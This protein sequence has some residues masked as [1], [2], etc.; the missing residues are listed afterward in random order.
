[1][2]DNIIPQHASAVVFCGR[3]GSGKSNLLVNLAERPEFYGKTKKD[4]PKT[5]YFDLILCL[6]SRLLVIMTTYRNILTYH[7]IECMI[8]ISNHH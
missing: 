3:S 5:G 8:E 1:M 6:C 4:N 7:Q 2:E